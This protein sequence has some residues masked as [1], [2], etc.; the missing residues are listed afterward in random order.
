[1][2][3]T[4]SKKALLFMGMFCEFEVDGIG[5]RRCW[6]GGWAGVFN[7]CRFTFGSSGKQAKSASQ[8]QAKDSRGE[9]FEKLMDFM[10]YVNKFAAIA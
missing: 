7:E 9:Y 5:R 4:I 3:S 6:S 10:E 1:M 8:G 2:A